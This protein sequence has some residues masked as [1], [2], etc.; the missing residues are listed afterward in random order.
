MAAA[1]RPIIRLRDVLTT[2]GVENW[3]LYPCHPAGPFTPRARTGPC[4]LDSDS[5]G[6]SPSRSTKLTLITAGIFRPAVNILRRPVV[7][8]FGFKEAGIMGIY[9][10]TETLP[11]APDSELSN[12]LSG[13]PGGFRTLLDGRLCRGCG[14]RSLARHG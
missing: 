6:F 8:Q 7:S 11:D 13:G 9:R 10:Q 1:L 5:C 14:L 2:S 4:G 12:C 3:D